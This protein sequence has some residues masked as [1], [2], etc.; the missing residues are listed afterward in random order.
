M[1]TFKRKALK[2][3]DELA[4]LSLDLPKNY[5]LI[6]TFSKSDENLKKMIYTFY[7]MYYDD[8]DKR[9]LILGSSPARS[10][11]GV[12]GVPFESADHLEEISCLPRNNCYRKSPSSSFLKDVIDKYGGYMAFYKKFYMNFVCPI[13]IVKQKNS[14]L[15]NCNYYDNKKLEDALYP[16]IIESLKNMINLGIDTS[17]CFCIGSGKNYEFLLKINNEYN[18]FDKIV[19]LEHPRFIMQYNLKDKDIYLNKYINSLKD[20]DRQG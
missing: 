1:V 18:F 3:N 5:C 20:I 4:E 2:F 15:T 16:F 12:V 14:R 9:Y 17:V 6:N 11:S 8:T 19:P 13:C 7:K 10:K